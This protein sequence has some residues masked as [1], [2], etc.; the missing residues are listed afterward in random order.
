MFRS[1]MPKDK[2]FFDLFDE[3]SEKIV[4][5]AE[6]LCK[7]LDNGPDYGE[8]AKQLKTLENEADQI[9]HRIVA[10]LHKTF[11]TPIDREDI[12]HLVNRLDDILDLTEGAASRIKLY[13]PESVPEGAKALARVLLESA[14]SVKDMIHLLHN[15]KQSEKILKLTVEIKRL[16]NEADIIRRSILSNLFRDEKDVFELIKW[17]DILEYIEKG[18]D[19]SD[20]VGNIVEGIVLENT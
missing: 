16:E 17:K 12:F 14:R 15:M 20:D 3:I 8:P 6:I 1:L 13:Q 5:G 18:T 4:E 9:A 19:R 11:I 10:Q 2:H 7:M